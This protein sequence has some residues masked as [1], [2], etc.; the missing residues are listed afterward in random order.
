MP[1]GRVGRPGIS[2]H[3][4][5]ILAPNELTVLDE[6]PITTVD[7]TLLDLAALFPERDLAR[8]LDRA[9]RLDLFDLAA[10][11]RV[12]SHAKGRPG[13][14]LLRIAIAAWQPR[15]TRSELEDR[16][17]ELVLAAGLP[18]P[19]LNVLLDGEQRTH[20][21]DAFWPSRSLVVQLDG[22]AFH[23]TRHDRERD[24]AAEADLELAGYR[25]LRLTWDDVAVHGP[26]T[27]RRL[28]RLLDPTSDRR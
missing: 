25:V 16:H 19:E 26:R 24:A 2:V 13:A 12:L 10:V 21:V 14:H 6:I 28:R 8:V 22:F 18:A 17:R 11:Q 1:R 3:P 5:R 23:R 7:R 15:H 4:S 9:E 20:E 27:I